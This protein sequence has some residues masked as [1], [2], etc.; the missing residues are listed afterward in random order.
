MT[1][2]SDRVAFLTGV[3]SGVGRSTAIRLAREGASV[4]GVDI[5][6][7]VPEDHYQAVAEIIS[8][9]WNVKGRTMPGQAGTDTGMAAAG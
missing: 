8:Y 6:E 7:E 3:A 9:G 1:R 4:F 2:F 5:D